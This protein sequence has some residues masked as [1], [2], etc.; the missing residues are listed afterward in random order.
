M[1]RGAL[2]LQ[3]QLPERKS[4]PNNLYCAFLGKMSFRGIVLLL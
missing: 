4:A 2:T 3:H 1:S